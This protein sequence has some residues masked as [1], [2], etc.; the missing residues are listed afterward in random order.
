[1]EEYA[2][3]IRTPPVALVS[4]VGLPE[5]HQ[6][7]SAYLHAEQPP[8]NTLALPDFGK[9]SVIASKIKEAVDSGE[10]AAGILKREWLVKHRTRVPA[11]VAA[12]FNAD[13]VTGDP[14]Q[15]LKVCTDLDGVKAAIRGRDAKL[16]VVIVRSSA[17]D[18]VS[19]DQLTT[20]RKRAEIDSKFVITM[21]QSDFA[22]GR[23]KS[24]QRLGSLFAELA[25][26]YYREEGRKIKT[27]IDKKSF[28]CSEFHIRYCFKAAVFAEFRREWAEA[29]KCYTDAYTALYEMVGSPSRLPPI[30]RL[31]EMKT[32]AEQLHFKVSTLLLHSGKVTDAVRWFQKHIAGSEV[33]VG[34]PNVDFL[35][36]EWLSRQFLV[37]AEL[38]ETSSVPAASSSPASTLTEWDFQPAYYYQTAAHYLRNK[39]DSLD[40]ISAAPDSA[41]W[42]SSGEST[43][44]ESIVPSMFVG[45]FSRLPEEEGDSLS[46]LP[47]TDEE[48]TGYAL[49]EAKRF[50]DSFEIIA[51]YRKSMESFTALKAPRMASSCGNWMA[52]EQITVSDFAGANKLLDPLLTLYRRERWLPLLW[53]ALDI[54]RQCSLQ[55]GHAKD[56]VQSSLEMAA[57]PV[58]DGKREAIQ[59][60]AIGLIKAQS[61]EG[62]MP[63]K[64]DRTIDL[65]VNDTSSLRAVFLAS[66][67]FHEQTVKPGCPAKL[68]LSLLSLLPLP[69]E[70]DQVELQFN[71]PASNFTA[72]CI[73]LAP[74]KWVRLDRE[75]QPA[76][77]GK[78]DCLSLTAALGPWCKIHLQVNSPNSLDSAVGLLDRV[79]NQPAGT[80]LLSAAGLKSIQVDLPD[81]EVD[82]TLPPSAGPALI[83]EVFRIPFSVSSRGGTA[84]LPSELKINLVDAAAEAAAPDTD[85]VELLAVI[86]PHHEEEEGINRIQKSFALVS[87]PA[88]VNGESWPGE[89][90]L[91]WRH[92]RVVILYVSLSYSTEGRRINVH[93]NLQI[94]GKTPLTVA[95]RFLTP[96]RHEPLLLS[97][98]H[99]SS[100]A[101]A[102]ATAAATIP[103][104]EPSILV[105]SALNC[106]HVPLKLVSLTVEP[107]AGE[108]VALRQAAGAEFSSATI[109][110]GEEFRQFISVVPGKTSSTVE[111]GYACLRWRRLVDSGG[112]DDVEV[113]QTLGT[114]AVE[115][116]PLVMETECPPW[117]I[118]GEPF[119]MQVRV[120]N[121]SSLLQEIKYSVGDGG[122]FVFS[123]PHQDKFWV[124][125]RSVH[126]AS[127][128]AVALGT[129]PQRLPS[130]N[131]TSVRYSAKVSASVTAS[132]IFVL[133]SERP[134]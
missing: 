20:L 50:Q 29:L 95:H 103:C 59:E 123:G 63:L 91:R 106:C 13:A 88:L 100:P 116:A 126:V 125:P 17:R 86:K 105:V 46:T 54:S 66:V 23:S 22:V 37:F 18:E 93:R 62:P 83:G 107:A 90:H 67:A 52:R 94:E 131:V 130:V 64:V 75:V 35:H 51:L 120:R 118:V 30:Q 21:V 43:A 38:L 97:S 55:L 73:T 2:E 128:V 28:S 25:N 84:T 70:I 58:Y 44:V 85:Q 47:L 60:Q 78:L 81:P 39:R 114:A 27:R 24:L 32:I 112:A 57:L 113:R 119:E 101:A 9:I 89:L 65:E 92:P 53:E 40:R 117:A 72:G 61:G 122:A 121:E 111:L 41:G 45:Q 80:L 34:P 56:Y 7:I 115:V 6:S 96:F 42:R 129:G 3:E 10:P 8:I 127:H 124:L 68:T 71:Q 19:E 133:P 76:Q 109:S 16:V 26:A 15:W 69:V 132:T 102:A 36:W 11:V 110:P 5:L 74:R 1:M 4:L 134:E 104:H 33:L 108:A 87:V 31:V 14:A 49:G 98:L 99:G 77:S 82:I 79:E 12:L 48:Y